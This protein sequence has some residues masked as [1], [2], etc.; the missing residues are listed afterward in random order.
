MFCGV[1]SESISLDTI[2]SLDPLPCL[3]SRD[4]LFGARANP[5]L[6]DRDFLRAHYV[7]S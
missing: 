4:I 3:D 7:G 6:G 2:M 5:M 1:G